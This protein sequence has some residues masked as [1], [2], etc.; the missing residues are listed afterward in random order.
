MAPDRTRRR[1]GSLASDDVDAVSD[2]DRAGPSSSRKKQANGGR[3]R[4]HGADE[5]RLLLWML[6]TW[7]LRG[8]ARADGMAVLELM[9]AVWAASMGGHVQAVLGHGAGGR[10]WRVEGCFG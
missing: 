4:E 5:V 7:L 9:H 10:R 8:D 2:E 6:G 1:S 3:S